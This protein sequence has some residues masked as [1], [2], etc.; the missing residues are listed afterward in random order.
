MQPIV[1][2]KLC[3]TCGANL[4]LEAPSGFCPSCLLSTALEID[5]SESPHPGA[6][7]NDF[8]IL[9]EIAR[10]GMGI[11]Y[12]ARQRVPARI[13]ALKMIL[14]SHID[15]A[16]AVARFRAEAEAA[17]SLDH[18]HI[19]PIYGVGEKDGAPFYSMKLAEGGNLSARIR[20]LTEAP[21]KCAALVA[22]LARAVEHAHE[23]GILHRDLKPGNV[24]FDGVGKAFVSDFG[25]AKWLEREA[26]LT[27]TLAILGTPYYMAPEQAAG[28]HSLTAA[29]DVYSL[30]AIL[31]HLL[32]GRPPFEGANAIEVLRNSAERP[33]PRPRALN[34]KVPA[35]LETICLKCLEKNSAVRYSSAGALADDL[36]RYLARRPIHARPASAWMHA[37]RWA[38]RNPAI[39]ALSAALLALLLSLF[40]V[41]QPTPKIADLGKSIAVL[42]FENLSDDQTNASFANAIQDDVL[43]NL[44]KVADLK[45]ISRASVMQYR[46]KAKNTREIGEALKVAH[47]LEGSVQKIGGRV[48]VNVQLIDTRSDA[49]IW[50]EQFD[51][52]LADVFA[53][54]S[55]LA[56]KIVSRLTATLS[57]REKASIE[58][59]PTR[60]LEAYNLYLRA[61]ELMFNAASARDPKAEAAKAIELLDQAVARDPSFALA[62]S[63]LGRVH[64]DLYYDSGRQAAPH[65]EQARACVEN[66]LRLAPDSGEAH[67]ANAF[68]LFHGVDDQ[69]RALEEF[70]VAT[71]ELPNNADALSWMGIL[72]RRM[73][74]WPE[75]LRDLRKATELDPHNG[76]P[77]I[78]LIVCYEALRNYAEADLAIE[79]ALI[80]IPRLTNR[81]RARKAEIA[82]LKGDT[83]A[84]RAI[85]ESI[86]SDYEPNGTIPYLRSR[87]SLWNREYAEAARV[88]DAI[89]KEELKGFT[90]A[91][92]ARD[93]AFIACAQN[94]PAKS[95]PVL[96]DAIDAWQAQ[97]G[98]SSD[99]AE[100]RSYIALWSAALGR[101][102]EAL[103]ESQKAVDLR[104]LSRDATNAPSLLNRQALVY[105][106][107]G[108]R[109]LA[110]K[111]LE[112]LSKIPGGPSLG[113][114]RLNPA[115]DVLRDEPRFQAVVAAAAE[116]LRLN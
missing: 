93:Q 61:R 34:N 22:A 19:L 25:L 31:F 24:L 100:A 91:W 47:L 115:W 3:E 14:P 39:A 62:Y 87:M 109:E 106:W 42:P 111:Q 116:P 113:E 36:D 86:P 43:T 102:D 45:V 20:A 101:K 81:F 7:F 48:R 44:A 72:E 85:L 57:P 76:R 90:R 110:L 26:D 73:G 2:Q 35:D 54:Q 70:A 58:T 95:E 69:R 16:E 15:S 66:A 27:Q 55:E 46:D 18:E 53:L 71:R 74:H 5:I 41:L 49:H 103:R 1:S 32:A 77:P 30:G 65:L 94:G 105:A 68:Y 82:L 79:R 97:I 64:V 29:T 10:G 78:D 6:H 23:H 21:R 52:D 40:F 12:R 88:L 9:E 107:C 99:E 4:D 98:G 80:A 83:Q 11:V 89:P 28:S 84:C 50:A 17:A 63:L 96:L 59:T 56:E 8:E 112:A 37:W 104:P 92:V 51:R 38:R 75:A 13:V 114:L 67:F 33:A 108:E 60:D